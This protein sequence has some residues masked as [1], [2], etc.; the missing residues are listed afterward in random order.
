MPINITIPNDVIN[1]NLSPTSL[2]SNIKENLLV[3]SW[4]IED[5][6]MKDK[7]Y[8]SSFLSTLRKQDI[9]LLQEWKKND[10]EEFIEK[11]NE[12]SHNKY[13]F[14][15]I[16]TDRVAV[17]FKSSNLNNLNNFNV[18]KTKAY[19]IKLEY[20]KPTYAEQTYTK[21]RQKSNI[22]VILY[23]YDRKPLCIISFHLSAYLPSSHPGFHSKQLKSLIKSAVKQIK[24]D[25][26]HD[27]DLI[28]GGDTNY[29]RT[30]KNFNITH[31]NNYLL[32]NLINKYKLKN[33]CEDKCNK[34]TTQTFKCV[35][36]KSLDKSLIWSFSK[37]FNESRLD[38]ILTNIPIIDTSI[39]SMCDFSDHSAILTE[40]MW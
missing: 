8:S 24:D 22:L 19:N 37:L 4:N 39:R 13:K 1:M 29:R 33:V 18:K 10:G 17:I 20:E 14:I 38:L 32:N 35:H 9:I 3:I 6:T 25:G 7:L 31:L 36:E 11:L 34:K 26:I 12:L 40:L 5:F 23:P 15:G 21:G 30:N 28:V 27:Y 16:F 2:L